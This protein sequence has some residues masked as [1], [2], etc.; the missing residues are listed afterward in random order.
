MKWF[1]ENWQ[2]IGVVGILTLVAGL[3]LGRPSASM[4]PATPSHQSLTGTET[5]GEDAMSTTTQAYGK[6]QHADGSNFDQLVLSSDA[7]VLVD[8]YADWCGPCQMIAPAL[9][10]LARENPEARIVKV[11][12]DQSPQLAARYGISS[13]PSLK[14]FKD[15]QVVGE[16]VGMANKARLKA[17]LGG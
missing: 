16:H 10:E 6:V 11:D 8:F 15:G 9:E 1:H 5:D 17:L 2:V 12:V 3:F 7:P 4:L 14:V 13:I